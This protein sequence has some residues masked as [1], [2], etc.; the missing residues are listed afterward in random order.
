MISTFL[1]LLVFQPSTDLRPGETFLRS[2]QGLP[3]VREVD[4]RRISE[5]LT[6][7]SKSQWSVA[8]GICQELD[9][10]YGAFAMQSGGAGTIVIRPSQ[11]AATPAPVL[12]RRDFLLEMATLR[13]YVLDIDGAIRE[14]AP[15]ADGK[16]ELSVL[17]LNAL[18]RK[19]DYAAAIDILKTVVLV[20][21][22]GAWSPEDRDV[23]GLA[24]IYQLAAANSME[25]R[26]RLHEIAFAM[27]QGSALLPDPRGAPYP[28]NIIQREATLL[29]AELS[30]REKNLRLAKSYLQHIL[31]DKSAQ[32]IYYRRVANAY[33]AKFAKTP[34]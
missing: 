3:I 32:G 6:A 17:R 33:L 4:Q 15:G 30:A 2:L 31:R 34:P 19:G 5:G 22:V 21:I 28:S 24:E 26:V 23:P 16:D 18:A 1:S 8:F 29:L 27:Q 9:S 13:L 10:I 20:P 25:D 12:L 11:G 7:L 14:L